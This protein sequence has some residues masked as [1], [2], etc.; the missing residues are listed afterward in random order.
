MDKSHLLS[1]QMIVQSL[2]EKNEFFH[3]KEDNK[4]L[5]NLEVPYLSAIGVLIYLTNCMQL[6]IM[7]FVNL[8]TRYSSAPTWKYWNRVNHIL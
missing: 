7:S 2:G 5:I 6:Y 1:S 8:L 4:E 3:S